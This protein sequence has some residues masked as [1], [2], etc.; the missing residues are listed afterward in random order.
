MWRVRRLLGDAPFGQPHPLQ[1]RLGEEQ[2]QAPI[3]RRSEVPAQRL[4]GSPSHRPFRAFGVGHG[5]GVG[6]VPSV[7]GT[8]TNGKRP[9]VD[10]QG[11][12]IGGFGLK[13]GEKNGY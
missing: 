1:D 7:N 12:G 5:V 9:A 13:C 11:L 2:G 4:F 10:S 3:E 6:H 8:R